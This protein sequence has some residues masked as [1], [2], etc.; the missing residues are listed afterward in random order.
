VFE[1]RNDA[2]DSFGAGLLRPSASSF[3][4]MILFALVELTFAAS[5]ITPRH[6]ASLPPVLLMTSARDDY[7]RVALETYRI[8]YLPRAPL[9]VAYL[10]ASTAQRAIYDDMTPRFIEHRLKNKVGQ[11][12]DFYPL[13]AAGETIQE[14][15][16]LVHQLPKEFRGVIAMVVYED[17]DDV[18]NRLLLKRVNGADF[19]ERLPFD[20]LPGDGPRLGFD[21][22]PLAE[23]GVY[24]FD[25]LRFFAARRAQFLRPWPTWQS[26]A[27]G[28]RAQ[29]TPPK[30]GAEQ[31][32]YKKRYK[33]SPNALFKHFDL[34]A[35]IIRS[36][37]ERHAPIVFVEAPANPLFQ[38][39]KGEKHAVYQEKVRAFAEDNGAEYWDLNP[40]VKPRRADFEDAVH[41]G[42]P[43]RRLKFERA[44][45]DRLADK[46]RDMVDAPAKHEEPADDD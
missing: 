25:H 13:I 1:R 2:D 20:A 36:A 26:P 29:P 4:G 35:E 39:L 34:L 14:S 15:A 17:K 27:R 46:L 41:L 38:L 3:A 44:L 24:F 16:L 40:E 18:R 9:A 22:T 19:E 10:G 45:C 6:L 8:R 37:K 12:V 33:H 43:A 42:D 31:D 21:G 5:L 30:R 23:T 28:S 32:A 7:A 11:K